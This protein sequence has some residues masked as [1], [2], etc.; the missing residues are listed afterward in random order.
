MTRFFAWVLLSSTLALMA[1]NTSSAVDLGFGFLKKKSKPD[2]AARA[3]ALIATLQSDPDEK[4]RKAAAEE[5]RAFDPRTVPEVIPALV[6]SFQRDPIPSV[7]IEAI[8][9]ISRLKPIAQPAGLAMESALQSDPDNKVRDALRAALFQYQINGYRTPP[10]GAISN[11]SNEPP[12]AKGAPSKGKM[13]SP[14]AS[15]ESFRPITNSMGQGGVFPQSSE[16]PLA[17]PKSTSSQKSAELPKPAPVIPSRSVPQQMP[18]APLPTPT[19]IPSTP[20]PVPSTPLPEI[21]IP[22]APSVPV[23]PSGPSI[24]VPSVPVPPKL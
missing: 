1:A 22:S 19:P 6:S 12:L 14:L 11:Q 15:P 24:P 13:P 2:A 10:T 3:K 4:K 16:P 7:R 21:K 23:P 5:L 17:K 20:V 18:S 9:S 8:E